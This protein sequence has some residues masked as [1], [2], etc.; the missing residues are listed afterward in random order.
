M[1]GNELEADS[2]YQQRNVLSMSSSGKTIDIK[3]KP[4]PQLVDFLEL[5]SLNVGGMDRLL[6]VRQHTVSLKHSLTDTSQHPYIREGKPASLKSL[7]MNAERC[8]SRLC[9]SAAGQG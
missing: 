1:T 9:F 5:C 6:R 3:V 8:V 2:A 7:V 4:S